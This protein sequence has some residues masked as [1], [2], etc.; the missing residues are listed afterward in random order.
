MLTLRA[1]IA[2]YSQW[3]TTPLDYT[4]NPFHLFDSGNDC[5]DRELHARRPAAGAQLDPPGPGR[6]SCPEQPAARLRLLRLCPDGRRR[7]AR[8]R[9]RARQLPDGFPDTTSEVF[10]NWRQRRRQR[11]R[12]ECRR[13]RALGLPGIPDR[14]LHRPL[15]QPG[16]GAGRDRR[17][18]Q[19]AADSGRA[20]RRLGAGL[21]RARLRDRRPGHGRLFG[22]RC[23]ASRERHAAGL[24]TASR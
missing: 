9:D 6:Q 8:S 22:H 7:R 17:R 18:R 1:A 4:I 23:G 10:A 3:S 19:P 21:H 12:G 15:A 20:G 2:D 24:P 16:A 14:R 5:G 11:R 13:Y